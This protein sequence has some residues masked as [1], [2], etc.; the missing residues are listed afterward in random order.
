MKRENDWLPLSSSPKNLFPSLSFQDLNGQPSVSAARARV[1]VWPR[2][3]HNLQPV[4]DFGRN[5]IREHGFGRSP[6]AVASVRSAWRSARLKR[7]QLRPC[8]A[9]PC[10]DR[11]LRIT[12]KRYR[13]ISDDGAGGPR[14]GRTASGK[15]IKFFSKCHQLLHLSCSMTVG[16]DSSPKRPLESLRCCTMPETNEYN[17]TT[18]LYEARDEC[19]RKIRTNTKYIRSFSKEPDLGQSGTDSTNRSS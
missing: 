12:I 13:S 18:Y 8:R 19:S 3:S 15:I 7:R 2:I 6:Q 16:E 5:T 1:H 4:Q 9:V 11:A 14:V 10:C 17:S